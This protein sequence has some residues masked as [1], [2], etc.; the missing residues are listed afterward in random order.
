[1]TLNAI[2]RKAHQTAQRKGFYP[3]DE[4]LR[5]YLARLTSNI[6]G[7]VS[8]LWEAFR[9]G[10]LDSPCDKSAAVHG[11]PMT[12]K[13]EELADILIRVLDAC[14]YLGVDADAC[15]TA[16][17]AYNDGREFRHGGKAA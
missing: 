11:R 9:N 13:E 2:A 1:M 10:K 5:H 16:K 6:H 14:A 8:E 7:E 17:M 12:C 15:V 3:P 4:D